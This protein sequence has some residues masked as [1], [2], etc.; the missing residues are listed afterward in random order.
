MQ[1]QGVEFSIDAAL[2]KRKDLKWDVS[3]NISFNKN[4]IVKLYQG[5]DIITGHFNFG[6]AQFV[7]DIVVLREGEPLGMFY[8]YVEDGYVQG[9]HGALSIIKYKDINNDG[10]INV[11]DKV[12]IGDP[13]PTF[14]YGFNTFLT[15]KAFS[16]SA[17][18]QGVYGNDIANISSLSLYEAPYRVNTFEEMPKNLATPQNPNA[19]YPQPE[20]RNLGLLFS[21]R[22]IE[23]GSYLRMQ[24]LEIGYT[25][26]KVSKGAYFFVS[27]E[28]L[29][30]LTKYS[31]WDPEV[32]A[33][34]VDIVQGVDWNTYPRAKSYTVGVR[35]SF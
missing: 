17:Y 21:K 13:N 1:N 30:T 6:G 32:N 15:Y 34:G 28:N 11:S 22:F 29:L 5:K 23:D 8:G 33:T 4:K 19:K 14:T 2:I 9:A 7:D 16:L 12:K 20:Q 18:F 10:V 3:G 27:G 24:H 26:Q 31:W 35:M 25:F